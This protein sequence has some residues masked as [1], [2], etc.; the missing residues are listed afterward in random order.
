M[1]LDNTRR[2]IRNVSQCEQIC[3]TAAKAF[4]QECAALEEGETLLTELLDPDGASAQT[5]LELRIK[6]ARR[7]G[8]R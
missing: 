1:L 7:S 4:R 2:A 8:D 5:G 6:S 3:L